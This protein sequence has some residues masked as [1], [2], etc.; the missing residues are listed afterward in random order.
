MKDFL[1]IVLL[2]PILRLFHIL[3]ECVMNLLISPIMERYYLNSYSRVDTLVW[4]DSSVLPLPKGVT[5]D[6]F[7]HLFINSNGEVLTN[8]FFIPKCYDVTGFMKVGDY[9][10]KK[11]NIQTTNRYLGVNNN[12]NKVYYKGIEH[13]DKRL[14]AVPMLKPA[15]NLIK[16]VKL[17]TYKYLMRT[18]RHCI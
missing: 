7:Y 6:E 18:E 3:Y 14:C 9:V 17:W 4:D 13:F 8:R 15:L 10:R 2:N 5:K 16:R 11:F 1:R 12:S